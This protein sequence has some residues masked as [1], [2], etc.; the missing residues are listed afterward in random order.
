MG[1]QEKNAKYCLS[2]GKEN[3]KI[4]KLEEA[5]KDFT[6][7]ITLDQKDADSYYNRGNAKSELC[8]HEGAINDYDEAIRLDPKYTKAYNNR[9]NVKSVLGRKKEA[10]NDYDEAIRLDPKY[11]KAYYGRG[12]VKREL[13]KNKEA[14][15]DFHLFVGLTDGSLGEFKKRAL[16][17]IKEIENTKKR[18]KKKAKKKKKKK[19]EQKEKPEPVAPE[20]IPAPSDKPYKD[21]HSAAVMFI[22]VCESTRIMH[23]HGVVHFLKMYKILDNIFNKT[24]NQN[25]LI[26]KKGLGDGFMAAFEDEVKAVKTAAEILKALK[27]YNKTQ[28]DKSQI[29]VR[30]GIDYGQVYR[31]DDDDV[32]GM[33]VNMAARI[34]GVQKSSVKEFSGNMPERIRILVSHVVYASIKNEW[35]CDKVGWVDLKGFEGTQFWIY[36][37]DWEKA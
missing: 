7:A 28:G 8:L 23:Y 34:E 30:I 13:G 29:N 11:T 9:G 12:L 17:F 3:A 32:F 26:F 14:A 22:D 37:V 1:D 24:A 35:E 27:V 2:C 31:G 20:P 15:N 5:V 16:S 33:R 4:G 36:N 19:A 25:G 6:E 10:I 18:K 21:I